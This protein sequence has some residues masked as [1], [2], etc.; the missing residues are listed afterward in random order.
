MVTQDTIIET[1][2]Y[3]SESGEY[4]NVKRIPAVRVSVQYP[5]DKLEA[6]GEMDHWWCQGKY[7][8]REV[9]KNKFNLERELELIKNS[10][11]LKKTPAQIK[12]EEIKEK[13]RDEEEY[14]KEHNYQVH[15]LEV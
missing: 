4:K 8:G 10:L 7:R 9:P 2:D 6:I 11:V 1:S 3:D 5:E 14:K 15:R 13:K 12:T